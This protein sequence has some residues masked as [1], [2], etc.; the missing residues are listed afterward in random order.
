M[1]PDDDHGDLLPELCVLNDASLVPLPQQLHLPHSIHSLHSVF[2][3]IIVNN[4]VCARMYINICID[5]WLHKTAMFLG[6]FLTMS[7]MRSQTWTR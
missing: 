1:V 4:R 3:I 7:D 5:I 2:V 6:E